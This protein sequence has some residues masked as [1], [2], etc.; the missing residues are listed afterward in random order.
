[1]RVGLAGLGRVGRCRNAIGP[2]VSVYWGA[3]WRRQGDPRVSHLPI[4]LLSHDRRGAVR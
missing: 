1:M 4:L 2:L 3:I